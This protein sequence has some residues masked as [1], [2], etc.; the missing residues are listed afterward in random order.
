MRAT[1][2]GMMHVEG[3]TRTST[4]LLVI[5]AGL[6][7][8]ATAARAKRGGIE[9][10]VSES[11]RLLS[12]RAPTGAAMTSDA[13]GEPQTMH[14]P[15]NTEA[16][17][18][19]PAASSSPDANPVLR[20]PEGTPGAAAATEYAP[21]SAQAHPA[22]SRRAVWFFG[23]LTTVLLGG[24]ET[25]GKFTV[26]EGEG[27]RG[28]SLPLHVHHREDKVL[29]VAEGELTIH[30]AGEEVAAPA[31]T[32]VSLPRGMEHSCV[33]ESEEARALTFFS[34]GGIEGLVFEMDEAAEENGRD[35][36]RLVAVAARYGCDITGPPPRGRRQSRDSGSERSGRG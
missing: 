29:Y 7:G 2:S 25:A 24:A 10:P 16:V 27:S 31:G 6:Y 4:P 22:A 3:E 28:V 20:H 26:L 13:G 32:T 8:V 19:T 15:T 21:F 33:V 36:E 35:L 23:W 9:P 14:Q 34:P 30:L 5:G 11:R 17:P 18:G 12:G 1:V